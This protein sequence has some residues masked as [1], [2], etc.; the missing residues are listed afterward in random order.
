MRR[1]G[2]TRWI[3]IAGLDLVRSPDGRFRVLEDQVRM[4]SGLAYALAARDALA[5]RLPGH[6][7][8][9]RDAIERLGRALR[10]ASPA[11]DPRVVLVSEGP[12]AP[13]WWEHERMAEELGLPLLEELDPEEADVAYQRT[14]DTEVGRPVVKACREGRL[15]CV[16]A[17][18]TGV[19]D[20]KVVHAYVP[21]LI[22][23]YLH[24]EPVLDS[25]RSYDLADG[26]SLEE[27]LDRREELVFKPRGEMGGEGVV[28]WS[29]A[30]E[31][32]RERALSEVRDAPER[33][34]AQDRVILSTHPTVCDGRLEPRHVD[35]RPY[36]VVT[37]EGPW[38]LPGGLSRV[39]L[40]RG[41]LIVN[42]GQGGGVKDTWVRP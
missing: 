12:E 25:L 5:G 41:S 24:E 27:A 15:A 33:F 20:D 34:V 13:A 21:E 22:R 37:N 7:A 11:E 14:G 30:S 18:G 42:S 35:F 1:A 39:A 8:P 32:E 3:A 38:V 2:V 40:E 26:A 28:V 19:C 36:V 10:D 4:P 23:F 6:P 31:D 16:N 29:Q 17:P 9:I